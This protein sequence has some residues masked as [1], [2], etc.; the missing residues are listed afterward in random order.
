MMHIV[1]V[2]SGKCVTVYKVDLFV[3]RDLISGRLGFGKEN[4]WL[5]QP[6]RTRQW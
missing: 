6:A 2:Q 4:P 1:H 5:L 3:L